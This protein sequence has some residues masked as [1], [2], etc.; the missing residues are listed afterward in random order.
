MSRGGLGRNDLCFC[1]SGRKYKKCCYPRTFPDFSKPNAGI[2]DPYQE[3]SAVRRAISRME[4]QPLQGERVTINT[5]DVGRTRLICAPVPPDGDGAALAGTLAPPTAEQVEAKYEAIRKSNP[6]GVTE[7]VVTY[8]YPEPFG[9]A[10]ARMVFDA[11]ECFRRADGRSVDVLDLFRGM[12]V[13]MADGGIGT[14]R[15]N[16]E[17]RYETPVPPLPDRNGLWT[18]RV[19]GQVKHTGYEVI[20][21][22]WAGQTI[23]GT[24]EHLIWSADRK[25]WVRASELRPGELVRV[26]GNLVAPVEWVGPRRSDR[27]EV[28]GIE[29]EYFHNYFVGTGDNAMLVHNGPDCLVKPLDAATAETLR[30]DVLSRIVRGD[31]KGRAF[32]TPRNQRTPT[33]AEFNP[34][35]AEVRAGDLAETVVGRKHGIFPEQAGR[36][37]ELSNEELI[38]FRVED[39]MSATQVKDGLSLTGGHHR[40]NEIIQ[41]V[42]AGKLDPNTIIRI[43]VHD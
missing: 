21:F 17:R 19:I 31:A 37:A 5:V 26:A 6:E 39:P 13:R 22:R 9:F 7:V 35:I 28:Y 11:D 14:I 43:L 20:E 16:P 2:P 38:R 3:R 10:E 33:L 27:I 25:G 12:Q 42:Q 29:V 23:T 41:R 15:G 34:R 1:G 40:T 18:S 36:V 24:P 32:G 4:S 8:T 30:E